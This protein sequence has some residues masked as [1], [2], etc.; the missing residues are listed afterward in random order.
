MAYPE[1]FRI[2]SKWP[3]RFTISVAVHPRLEVVLIA[4]TA[5]V[6]ERHARLSHVEVEAESRQVQATL[7][8][9]DHQLASVVGQLFLITGISCGSD[10]CCC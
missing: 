2:F 5:L 8:F 7:A 10:G 6:V 1:H 3:T 9:V 4:L